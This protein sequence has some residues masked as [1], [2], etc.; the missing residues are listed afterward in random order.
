MRVKKISAPPS[1]LEGGGFVIKDILSGIRNDEIDPFLIWHE[2]PR[3][4]HNPGEMPGAPLHPHRGMME[5][6][7]SKEFTT[8]PGAPGNEGMNARVVAGGNEKRA[9][10]GVGDFE[11]G[12]VGVG[13]E[14]EA[15]IHPGWSGF[16][17]FFQL[18]VNLPAARKFDAPYFQRAS[19]A[20]L[21]IVALGE[22]VQCKVLHGEV[23]GSTSP[24]K[25]ADVEWQYLDFSL[26]PGATV[27]Y[28]PPAHM[29][30][31]LVYV[32]KGTVTIGGQAV[33]SGTCAVLDVSAGNDLGAT[34]DSEGC[35]FMFVAGRP[36]REPIVQHGPFVMSTQ[37]QIMECFRDFQSNRLC[38]EPVT[39]ELYD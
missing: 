1:R 21:P 11:L 8:D 29:V 39:Y 31:R 17:H 32:Y 35:S 27:S 5:C 13:M 26:I 33:A 38:P 25:C 22:G 10:M 30:T 16:L 36:N 4:H 23:A 19:H 3:K 18:W 14:H 24:T 28:A 34:A 12:K 20:R 2:L 37:Q 6:P 15:L 9:V 7:Y